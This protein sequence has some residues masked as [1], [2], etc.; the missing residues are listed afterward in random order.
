MKNFSQEPRIC[1]AEWNFAAAV[2][3]KHFAMIHTSRTF[4]SYG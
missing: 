3:F 2:K 1:E 4:L